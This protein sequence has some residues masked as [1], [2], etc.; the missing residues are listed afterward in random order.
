MVLVLFCSSTFAA[1]PHRM[2]S[3]EERAEKTYVQSAISCAKT[4]LATFGGALTTGAGFLGL[5]GT[6]CTAGV[7]PIIAATSTGGVLTASGL[8]QWGN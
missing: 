8:G 3:E 6:T 5:A 4:C 7:C 1:G 2:E